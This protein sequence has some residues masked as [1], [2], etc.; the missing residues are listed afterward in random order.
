M[1]ELKDKVA[2]I[3]GAGRGI[4]KAAVQVFAQQGAK[5]VACSV[6]QTCVRVAEE[7]RERGYD[8]IGVPCDVSDKAQLEMLVKT[9][10]DTYGKVD[11]LVN[12][13]GITRDA[14]MVKMSE[15]DWDL[16]LNTNLKGTFLLTQMIAPYMIEQ[17]Y[18]RVIN[19]TSGAGQRGNFGQ[20]NYSA[21][22]GGLISLTKT[23]AIEL[24]K[25]GI[26]VNAVSPGVVDTDILSTV[27]PEARKRMED[28]IFLRRIGKPEEI[29][30]AIAF[31]AS[32]KASFITGAVLDANGGV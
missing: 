10:L 26:T 30:W 20:A 3:T 16:V 14:Q 28:K 4:G 29:A 13:A 15:E 27:P 24:G 2:V 9:T 12:N 6:S 25:K 23:M 17:G 1:F 11:I 5:V 22:K 31:L 32:D 21:S 18:G 19:I 8:V 7:L